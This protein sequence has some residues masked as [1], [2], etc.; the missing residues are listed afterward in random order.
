[1]MVRLMGYRVAAVWAAAVVLGVWGAGGCREAAAPPDAQPVVPVQE[2]VSVTLEPIDVEQYA[3]V[4]AGHRGQV[5]LV[6]FWAT[7]CAPCVAAFPHTV[8]LHRRLAD[9]GLVVI[10]VSLDD[11]EDADAVRVF[12][13]GQQAT[14]E[15][16]HSRY[17]V[18]SKAFELFD[19]DAVPCVKLYDREGHLQHVFS[20]GEAT[21]AE[22]ID[23][24]LEALL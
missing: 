13:A 15:N 18:G 23:R 3:A 24:A 7:W 5:V 2:P 6:D 21:T 8:E 11:P 12:L 4:L 1:M 17:G 16:Y 14:F 10:S 22:E 9:R 20:G 19:L